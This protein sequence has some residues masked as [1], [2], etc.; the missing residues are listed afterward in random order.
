MRVAR[1]VGQRLYSK[2][3]I[4]LLTSAIALGAGL[5][6][7][8][9]M[10]APRTAG[11]ALF[12]PPYAH[13]EVAPNAQRPA[14]FADIVEM[15]KPAV[16]SVKVKVNAGGD[17]F[18]MNEDNPLR[19][20]PFEDFFRRFGQ[21]DGP[22]FGDRGAR[23]QRRQYT[24]G[25]GSGFFISA[26]GYAVTNNHVVDKA[27]HVDVTTDDGKTYTAK[28]IGTD[29]RTDLALI[30][31]DG[32]SDFPFVR[33]AD[34]SPRIG[35]WVLA[36]GNPFG[37]GGTVTAG[38]VSARGRDIN[39]GPYD[40]FI[41]IDAAVNKG[42]SG[43][44]TFDL[45]GNVIGV[46]TAIF[47]GSIEQY[48]ISD[49]GSLVT[50]TD[51]VEICHGTPFDEDY[52]V[53]DVSDAQR[54]IDAASARICLFGH[55]HVPAIYATADPPKSGRQHLSTDET[56]LPASGRVIINVGSV[57]QPRDGDPRAA[58]GVLDLDRNVIR[59]RRVAYDIASAQARIHRADLPAS[60]A[61][62]L[63]RGQ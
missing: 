26:D 20:T 51:D 50:V 63:E 11:S 61:A 12:A 60:L 47:S 32:R 49:S 44:P 30:K 55:T 40:D 54:A 15:V 6:F 25:Q 42:N 46:N 14:G 10:L 45:D 9:F 56:E 43:G 53:F 31:V 7:S 39:A 13:A 22:R 29:D 18:S 57:G 33:L 59:M 21:P 19:G 36:V 8:D 24:M 4:F 2:R 52:Y 27:E 5:M 41:Q 16:I 34:K 37:L 17:S 3:R 23:P 62:R 28:V 48:S 1:G 58:Y 38:I 35:D